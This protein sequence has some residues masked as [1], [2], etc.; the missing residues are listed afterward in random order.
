MKLPFNKAVAEKPAAAKAPAAPLRVKIENIYGVIAQPF[1]ADL[2]PWL[3]KGWT[4]A[5]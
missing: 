2:A 4:R 5:K 3:A 1:E